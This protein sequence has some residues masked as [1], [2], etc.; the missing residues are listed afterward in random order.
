M[1]ENNEK[2]KNKISPDESGFSYPKIVLLGY[3]K[4]GTY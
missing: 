4:P 2:G 3:G 1:S